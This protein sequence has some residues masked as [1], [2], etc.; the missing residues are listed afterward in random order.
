MISPRRDKVVAAPA[1]DGDSGEDGARS[2]L[3]RPI[4]AI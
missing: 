2:F 3:K 1:A 4:H